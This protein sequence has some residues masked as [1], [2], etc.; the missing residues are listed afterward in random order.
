MNIKRL[1]RL[2]S[3]SLAVVLLT[4][5]CI[6]LEMDLT[7]ATDD[8][9]SGTMV[10]AIA[11]SITDLAAED[12]ESSP[13]S[14]TQELFPT[15]PDVKS[16]PFDDGEYVGTTYTFDDLPLEEL[17]P[18]VGDE[19]ALSIK[20]QGDNLVVSGLLDTGSYEADLESNPLAASLTEGF[21]DLT[22]IKMSITLPGEIIQT[23]GEVDGQTITWTGSFGEK[24]ELQAVAASPLA[25]PINWLLIIGLAVLALGLAAGLGFWFISKNKPKPGANT[26]SNKSTT[27]AKGKKQSK[28]EVLAAEALALRPWY[29]KKRFAFPAIGALAFSLFAIALGLLLPAQ[30][31]NNSADGKSSS[32]TSQRDKDAKA[33]G[34]GSGE[35]EAA[36]ETEAA[37]PAPAQPAPAPPAPKPAPP[38]PSS[39]EASAQV[40]DEASETEGQYWA[41]EDA[42]T[43]WSNNW[44]SRSGLINELVNTMG[45]SYADAEYGVDFQGINWSVEAF[46][47][48]T[49]FIGDYYHSY[50]SLFNTLMG[51]G[52]SAAEAEYGV[53]ALE[54]DWFRE[55]YLYGVD[56]FNQGYLEEEIYNE[57]IGMGFS[58]DEAFYGSYFAANPE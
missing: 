50:Q 4:T 36:Q 19:S 27:E 44:Y 17:A 13:T 33:A 40:A 49:T 21:A 2:V 56:L 3:V 10:F 28:A 16:E 26:K 8:T 14:S 41:R 12:A 48:A 7:V 42:Y 47:M 22:S 18:E 43:F 46:G 54:W 35:G 23:N 31:S 30:D 5:G 24:L 29:Q 34:D 1:W 6:K 9:V 37:A 53:N 38:A 11:K 15:N 20:R 55:A 52:F 45:H 51:E 25:G 57:L 58:D 39:K 32:A